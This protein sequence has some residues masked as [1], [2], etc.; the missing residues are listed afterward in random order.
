M[1]FDRMPEFGTFT[2]QVMI[3]PAYSG[4]FDNFGLLKLGYDL[5]DRP[6]GNPNLEGNFP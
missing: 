3:A 5:L 2:D 4:A 1:K 6:L